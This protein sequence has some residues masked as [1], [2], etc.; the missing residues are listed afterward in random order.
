MPDKMATQQTQKAP[1]KKTTT[2]REESAVKQPN[3]KI[4]RGVSFLRFQGI[5]D[6]EHPVRREILFFIIV[7][8]C[9]FAV[10][11]G[12][13]HGWRGYLD[14]WNPNLFHEVLGTV[15][16]ALFCVWSYFKIYQTSDSFVARKEAQEAAQEAAELA[17]KKAEQ[18]RK[19]KAF[20]KIVV[21]FESAK[22]FEE[23]TRIMGDLLAVGIESPSLRQ[24]AVDA[25]L[26]MNDWMVENKIYLRTQNL[27]SWRLK[28][29]LF[30][31]SSRF[32]ENPET[33]DASIKA[34][35]IVENII[36]KHLEEF[37]AGHNTQ[38][39]DLS[40]KCFPTLNL[41]AKEIPAGALKM[42]DGNY[43]QSSFSEA[44]ITD[45]SFKNNDMYGTSFWRAQ[46]HNIDFENTVVERGKLRTN[47]QEVT[48][49]QAKEFFT[50]KEWELCLLSQAQ[51]TA[52]FGEEPDEQDSRFSKW[53]SGK[54]RRDK[55]YFGIDRI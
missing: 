11:W 10:I 22:T 14:G 36:R 6:P 16:A 37:L 20:M 12:W 33:Q 3:A 49:L 53:L 29:N 17:R 23:R 18:D 8:L 24:R 45:M 26:P 9:A 25:L 30:E 52:F 39:L 50:T 47:L 5:F 34:I 13:A 4:S 43:W 7:F 21:G 2:P 42:E 1:A 35:N 46:L 38:T 48:N 32:Q 28:S 55:L 15:S 19:D 54:I 31:R 44:N 51:E 40:G 27:V 41:S